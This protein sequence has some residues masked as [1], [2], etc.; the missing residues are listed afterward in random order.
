MSTGYNSTLI[1]TF[2]SCFFY[3]HFI[4][5]KR[6]NY[7]LKIVSVLF[8]PY[9][10]ISLAYMVFRYDSLKDITPACWIVLSVASIWF[11]LGPHLVYVFMRDFNNMEVNY[12]VTEKVSHWF[13]VRSE[14]HYSTYKKFML[15]ISVLFS[16]TFI[17]LMIAYPNILVE[18]VHIST[19]LTDPFFWIIIVFLFWLL[20]YCTNA[21]SIIAL[22][23]YVLRKM[24][25][26]DVFQYSVTEPSCKKDINQILRL[27]NKVTIYTCSGLLFVPLAAFFSFQSTY[28]FWFSIGF[29]FF[30]MFLLVSILYPKMK[31]RNYMNK[32]NKQTLFEEQYAYFSR[33]NEIHQ[34]T[35]TVEETLSL[36]NLYYHL[37][38]LKT[39]GNAEVKLINNHW[40]AYASFAI[41]FSLSILGFLADMLSV[42]DFF[43]LWIS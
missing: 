18:G 16:V 20:I 30:S 29:L 28:Q 21:L 39:A 1:K 4:S 36:M 2:S 7:W 15:I 19:G 40:I 3:R 8:I 41:S 22:M 32:E 38:E 14:S 9:V 37:Q 26:N 27:C 42:S 12:E 10:L 17:P 23:L 11:V 25:A 5:Q 13:D 43:K 34:R 31:I 6:Q 24:T 33:Y 35:S